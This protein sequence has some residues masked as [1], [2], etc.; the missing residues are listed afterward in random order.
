MKGPEARKPN[1]KEPPEGGARSGARGHTSDPRVGRG[2]KT[3]RQPD[4]RHPVPEHLQ[5][6]RERVLSRQVSGDEG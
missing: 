3:L 6:A 1:A 4:H 2:P 5:E